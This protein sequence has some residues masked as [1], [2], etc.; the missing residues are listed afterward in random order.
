MSAKQFLLLCLVCLG[1]P[2][3]AAAEK[4]R[5]E[6]F[7]YVEGSNAH[8]LG[9]FL[10]QSADD[11]TP[12]LV[13]FTGEDWQAPGPQ[14]TFSPDALATLLDAGIAVA[15]V[16]HRVYPAVKGEGMLQDVAAATAFVLKNKRID[17]R[18]KRVY[19]LGYGSGA[20]LLA[21][22]LADRRYLQKAGVAT[23]ELAG[24]ML[25]GGLY[26]FTDDTPYSDKQ[27]A[28][29]KQVFGDKLQAF[30]PAD[31]V[32]RVTTPTVLINPEKDYPGLA[33]DARLF[34]EKLRRQGNQ[35]AFHH[36]IAGQDRASVLQLKKPGNHLLDQILLMTGKAPVDK[37]YAKEIKVERHWHTP[38]L[39]TETFWQYKSLLKEY[40]PNPRFAFAVSR[41]FH[42][43]EHKLT[44]WP[45]KKYYAIE[46]TA[47]LEQLGTDKTGRGEYLELTNIRD[48]KVFW[49][50]SDIKA[51]NPVVVVGIDD[52]K[53]LYKFTT[54][55]QAKRQY[56]WQETEQPSVMVRPLGA[57]IFFQKEPPDI[58]NPAFYAHYALTLDSFKLHKT[59]PL[60][61]LS[62]FSPAFFKM[63]VYTNGC[64]S[65]HS[66]RGVGTRAHHDNALTLEAEGGF[67]L[68]LES[69]PPAVWREFVFNQ[70]AVANKI[71]VLPNTLPK[72]FQQELYETIERERNKAQ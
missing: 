71:G 1:L 25:V 14:A 58:Y 33:V 38:P 42:G 68:P 8:V 45:Y 7:R 34:M 13:M 17:Y 55:Y 48:E 44:V 63:F 16:R 35:K 64:T 36:V 66:F 3:N 27:L 5:V 28:Y 70:E 54:F 10:P 29:V 41:L 50:L 62:D 18:P 12:L 31:N 21:L 40:Q 30:S 57:F 60:A 6:Q 46:L 24:A 65:C 47:L 26:H 22:L 53:N 23:K 51:Y 19:L 56:S 69:Y 11:S 61:D 32:Q 39:T 49:K 37:T 20:H 2:C 9:Y 72:E 59:D 15:A 67:A 43:R 52:E 4:Y